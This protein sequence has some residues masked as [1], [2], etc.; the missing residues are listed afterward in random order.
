VQPALD[1]K[2]VEIVD[3][4]QNVS[5]GPS[6]ADYS[7]A[8]EDRGNTLA[9]SNLQLGNRFVAV[10]LTFTNRSSSLIQGDRVG[11]SLVDKNGQF[12]QPTVNVIPGCTSYQAMGYRLQPTETAT[13]CVIYQVP[14]A[15]TVDSFQ[16]GETLDS[17]GLVVTLAKWS[18]L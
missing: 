10:K 14:D 9:G 4:A 11:L 16:F 15:A 1:V 12:Y 8:S 6:V 2:A 13:E 17:S 18:A 7:G 3:P 5:R